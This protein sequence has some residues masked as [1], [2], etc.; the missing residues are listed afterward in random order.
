MASDG[1]VP[2][3]VHA[4]ERDQ[5]VLALQGGEGAFHYRL[6][7]QTLQDHPVSGWEGGRGIKDGGRGVC[8][9]R[10]IKVSHQ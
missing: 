10:K 3:L 1:A 4:A 6:S 9:S 5:H 8:T 7:A 2:L